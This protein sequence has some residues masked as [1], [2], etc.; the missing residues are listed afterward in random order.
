MKTKI[1]ELELLDRAKT[2]VAKGYNLQ[3]SLNQS[4]MI[5][6]LQ[7]KLMNGTAHFIYK[8][9]NNELREAF[10]TLLSKVVTNNINGN[11]EPKRFYNCQ[12]YFDIESQAWRSFKYENLVT[13][14]N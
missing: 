3:Q 9:K 2:M 13:I 1:N 4:S 7:F 6:L 11:G 10:G 5:E 8:K 14:L 12:A